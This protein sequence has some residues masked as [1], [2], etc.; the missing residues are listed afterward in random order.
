LNDIQS[1]GLIYES[2]SIAIRNGEYQSTGQNTARS[3]ARITQECNVRIGTGTG[4]IIGTGTG[5]W[6]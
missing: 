6:D 4:M 5:N 3:T 1:E 2:E